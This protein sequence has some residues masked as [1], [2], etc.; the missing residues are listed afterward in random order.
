VVVNIDRTGGLVHSYLNGIKIDSTVSINT[1]TGNISNSQSARI[2]A[3]KDVHADFTGSIDELRVYN[4]LLKESEIMQLYNREFFYDTITNEVFDTT[5]VVINDTITTEVF[6]TT[7]VTHVD[8]VS[9]TDTLIIEAVLTDLGPPENTNTLKVYPNPAKD[10]LYINTGEFELMNGY[11]LKIINQ[12][13]ETVFDTNIEEPL[14][15]LNLSDWTGYGMYF[16]QVIDTE[17]DIT[18]VRKIILQ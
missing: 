2:G 17:G 3:N 1:I 9:V 14:Y 18:E 16:L 11:R 10:Y 12:L 7:Y 13:G 4:R 5:F 6:D 8:S 15:E